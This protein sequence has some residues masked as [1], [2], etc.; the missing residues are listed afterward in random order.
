MGRNR[1]T[2]LFDPPFVSVVIPCRNESGFIGGCLDSVLAT[3]YPLGRLEVLV[4]DGMSDDGTR[5]EL[6]RYSAGPSIVRVLDNPKGI[7]PAALNIGVGHARGSVLIRM[8]AHTEYPPNYISGLVTWL[9]RSGADNVG[10]LWRTLPGDDTTFARAIA[11]ALSHPF[12]VGNA[13]FR[14]GVQE[15]KWVDTV[16]FGC[17]RADVFDRIGLFDEELVRNQDD[18]FNARLLRH[19]GRILLVPDVVSTYYAR[20]SAK[21]LWRTYFQYGFFKPLAIKKLGRVPTLRQLVPAAFV[22][23]LALFTLAGLWLPLARWTLLGILIA[24]L[25]SI[26]AASFSA[27]GPGKGLRVFAATA[28]VFPVLHLAYGIGFLRGVLDLVRP[29]GLRSRRTEPVPLS[30]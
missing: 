30:R 27:G 12:G 2:S 7:T 26:V 18:E 3:T 10:G 20:A 17:Y 28:V 29:N 19:G 13:H 5:D 4:V 22:L 1:V 15:P 11:G 14:I 24:Y 16:P 25:G 6:A 9:E 23:S 8:D 21:K